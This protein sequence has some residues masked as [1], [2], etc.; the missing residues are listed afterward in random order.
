M[1][2]K[3]LQSLLKWPDVPDCF[4]W[5]AL[6]RRGH[7]RMRNEYAQANKLPGSIVE[8]QPLNNYISRNYVRDPLGRYFF[9]NGAQR[10]FITLD[11]SPWI[12][13]INQTPDG[14]Q[15]QTQCESIFE[16]KSALS[17][18][19]GNIYI[20]GLTSVNILRESS[21]SSFI[22]KT[23]LTVG[24]LHDHDLG[25]FADCA[26]IQEQACSFGGSWSWHDQIL[27]LEPVH[28][29]ELSEQFQF[30]KNPKPITKY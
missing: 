28:S 23:E 29:K 6:D 9:Q 7:W 15:I 1:D 10:V 24:L 12:V 19:L 25:L 8:H 30:E 14:T 2:E 3:T 13:R 20:V 18:E 17:D 21:P 11:T 22:Q 5:L 4:G 27:A 26:K 16:P